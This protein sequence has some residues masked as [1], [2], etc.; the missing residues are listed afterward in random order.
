MPASDSIN[1]AE[2]GAL[3]FAAVRLK[4]T[5]PLAV[6]IEKR[7]IKKLHEKICDMDPKKKILE[8]FLY[9]LRKYG[10]QIGQCETNGGF[11]QHEECKTQ[12]TEKPSPPD[13]PHEFKCPISM[14]LMYD[15]VIINSG[16]TYER[17]WIEKWFSEGNDTCPI[18]HIKLDNLCSTPNVVIKGLIS[19]WCSNHGINISAPCAQTI[20]ASSFSKRLLSFT[21]VASIGSSMND[22]CLQ[23]SNVSLRSSDT[24]CGSDL[25]DDDN[26]ANFSV[27]LPRT[28]S[29]ICVS[30]SSITAHSIIRVASFSKLDSFPWESQCR[31]V[32]DIKE[33]LNKNEQECDLLF[34]KNYMKPLVKFL[35][36]AYDSCDEKAQ[37]D[38]VEVLLA[39]LSKSR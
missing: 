34:N 5:S 10:G 33:Q 20:P 16:K 4:I 17:V 25:V 13:P 9:L 37:D 32:Q 18:T 3:E 1:K 2:L 21:S 27:G 38:S 6:L 15:P 29:G 35:K 19:K 7:S 28:S 39:I 36:D 26:I 14:R 24:N 31:A 30:Q 22:L 23:V 8:Y 12:T 11:S